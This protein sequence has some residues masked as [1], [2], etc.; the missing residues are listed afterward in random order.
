MTLTN[1][2]L[3]KIT[4]I[5]RVYVITSA[6]SLGARLTHGKG[7]L[8]DFLGPGMFYVFIWEVVTRCT[9]M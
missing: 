2:M 5:Q 7:T 3:N 8:G 1:I 9:H 6:Y 4:K